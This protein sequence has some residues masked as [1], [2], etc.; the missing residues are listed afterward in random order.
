MS[1]K[2]HLSLFNLSDKWIMKIFLIHN[3]FSC[4]SARARF[5]RSARARSLAL[6]WIQPEIET[7]QGDSTSKTI[8]FNFLTKLRW[9]EIWFVSSISQEE[10]NFLFRIWAIVVVVVV[11]VVVVDEVV[12]E[13]CFQNCH[14]WQRKVSKSIMSLITMPSWFY[15]MI[16]NLYFLS[17]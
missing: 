3:F 12:A 8:F 17:L 15:L 11:V 9:K 6:I 7:N 1:Y 5:L 4:P 2:K 16:N 10:F 14:C 13:T